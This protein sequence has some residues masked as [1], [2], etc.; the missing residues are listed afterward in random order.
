MTRLLSSS[1]Y[2]ELSMVILFPLKN[3][4][5]VYVMVETILFSS[6]LVVPILMSVAVDVIEMV[7]MTTKTI[8]SETCKQIN[9]TSLENIFDNMLFDVKLH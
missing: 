9:S 2:F 3:H 6:V 7:G 8:Y 1:L 5:T 4:V